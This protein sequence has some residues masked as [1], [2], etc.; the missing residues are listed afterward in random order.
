MTAQMDV[1]TWRQSQICTSCGAEHASATML[2]LQTLPAMAALVVTGVA[3]EGLSMCLV[4]TP[5][6]VT[7]P[8][9]RE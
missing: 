6:R 9:A 5:A 1:R 3:E 2:D 7:R 4:I 8:L